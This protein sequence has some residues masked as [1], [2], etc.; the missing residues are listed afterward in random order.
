MPEKEE[1]KETVKVYSQYLKDIPLES[2]GKA[3]R[4]AMD[5]KGYIPSAPDVIKAYNAKETAFSSE[6][7]YLDWIDSRRKELLSLSEPL[8]RDQENGV[9]DIMEKLIKA[10]GL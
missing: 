9:N 3:F 6:K 5:S 1:F 2:L 7:K 10:A 8:P 4:D